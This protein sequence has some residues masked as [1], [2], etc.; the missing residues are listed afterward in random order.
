MSFW[1]AYMLVS[2]TIKSYISTVKIY[3]GFLTILL[4]VVRIRFS[5]QIKAASF[6]NNVRL[7]TIIYRTTATSINCRFNIALKFI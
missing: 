5:K 7:K 4:F 6:S 1:K 2:V 3:I